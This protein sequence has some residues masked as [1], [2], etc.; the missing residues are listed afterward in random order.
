MPTVRIDH[1]LVRR[2]LA[3][4][5]VGLP[6]RQGQALGDILVFQ[7]GRL[8]GHARLVAARSVARP[9]LAGRASWYATRTLDHM[10]GWFS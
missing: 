1:P 9:S 10:R 8:V 7:R 2:V 4:T 6:V 5:E 3:P